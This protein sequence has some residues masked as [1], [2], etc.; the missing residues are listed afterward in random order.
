MTGQ[1]QGKGAYAAHQGKFFYLDS[2][3]AVFP[4]DF[5]NETAV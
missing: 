4:K 5:F 3:V 2:V 1:V